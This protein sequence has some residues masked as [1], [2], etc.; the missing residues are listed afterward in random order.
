MVGRAGWVMLVVAPG[1]RSRQ[2]WCSAQKRKCRHR[3]RHHVWDMQRKRA[4]W[5]RRATSNARSARRVGFPLRE[6]SVVR[7][8]MAGRVSGS[9]TPS[10][11]TRF[12]PTATADTAGRP[13]AAARRRASGVRSLCCGGGGCF[14]F[15]MLSDL[16]ARKAPLNGC[17]NGSRGAMPGCCGVQR[18]LWG[19]VLPGVDGTDG[20]SR[21]IKGIDR[22][23]CARFPCRG[24][25]HPTSLAMCA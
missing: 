13:S 25:R 16:P 12:R 9:P 14:E 7:G 6:Y 1:Y 24:D 23:S 2:P 3:W 15:F 17:C 18:G 11:G 22:V 20:G 19:T 8:R 4:A 10:R 5:V 21:S